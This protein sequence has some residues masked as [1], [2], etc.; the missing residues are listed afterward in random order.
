MAKLVNHQ[1]TGT[2]MTCGKLYIFNKP[3][4]YPEICNIIINWQIKRI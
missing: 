4:P 1:A 2:L 3:V